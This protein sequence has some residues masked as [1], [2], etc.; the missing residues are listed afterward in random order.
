MRC[1][2]CGWY[3]SKHTLCEKDGTITKPYESCSNW[4]PITNADHIR[5]MTN[6]EL[7]DMIVDRCCHGL[8]D[9]PDNFEGKDETSSDCKACWLDWLKQEI[10]SI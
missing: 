5:A 7:V 9:C 2:K 8:Y 3:Y 10:K 4:R 1:N 6:E